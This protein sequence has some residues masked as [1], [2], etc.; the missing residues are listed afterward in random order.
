MG[1]AAASANGAQPSS[2]VAAVLLLLLWADNTH[3]PLSAAADL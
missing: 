2:A 3:V 1:T